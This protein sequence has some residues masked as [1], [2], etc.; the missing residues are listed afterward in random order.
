MVAAGK[1]T[2]QLTLEVRKFNSQGSSGIARATQMFVTECD[3]KS[4][5][6]NPKQCNMTAIVVNIVTLQGVESPRRQDS[7]CFCEEETRWA[8]LTCQDS[9]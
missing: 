4:T 7:Q 5:L 6:L 1:E 3:P 8:S 9:P 2:L